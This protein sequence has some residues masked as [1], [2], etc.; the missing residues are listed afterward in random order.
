ML[1]D[2]DHDLGL[3]ELLESDDEEESPVDLPIIETIAPFVPLPDSD[4][5]DEDEELSDLPVLLLDDDEEE[6]VEPWENSNVED[7]PEITDPDMPLPEGEPFETTIASTW[8]DP[9]LSSLRSS[10]R[11]YLRSCRR[12][13]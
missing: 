3:P 5:G 9:S 4:D 10:V 7:I 13:S 12:S 1:V 11:Y 8:T 6:H 2:V